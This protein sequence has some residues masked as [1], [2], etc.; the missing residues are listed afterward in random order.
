MVFGQNTGVRISYGLLIY[1][2][3]YKLTTLKLYSFQNLC[4]QPDVRAMPAGDPDVRS[5]HESSPLSLPRRLLPLHHLRHRP[6]EGRPLRHVRRRPLLSTP[7]RTHDLV[8][9]QPGPPLAAAA[10]NVC[11][12]RPSRPFSDRRPLPSVSGTFASGDGILVHAP[13]GR[14][15]TRRAPLV[16]GFTLSW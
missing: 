2:Y 6:Q 12:N 7:L 1:Q 5:S 13:G 8:A 9:A 11:Q 16:P 4:Q 10:G 3:L 15:R 14:G